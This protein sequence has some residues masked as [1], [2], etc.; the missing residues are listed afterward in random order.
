MEICVYPCISQNP[1]IPTKRIPI[2]IRHG[3]NIYPMERI[4][5]TYYP[6]M[7]ISIYILN[8]D[9]QEIMCTL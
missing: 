8:L 5:I 2:W 6:C 3:Y 7:W 9:V 4:Q 1:W